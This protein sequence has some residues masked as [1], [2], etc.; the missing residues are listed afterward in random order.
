MPVRSVRTV[1]GSYWLGA[2]K[3]IGGGTNKGYGV[4]A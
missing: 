4:G 3:T 1:G 2:M